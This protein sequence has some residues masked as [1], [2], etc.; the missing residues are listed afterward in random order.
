LKRLI[1]FEASFFCATSMA[2]K[3]KTEKMSIF[4]IIG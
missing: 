1:H 3:N 4:L 2:G